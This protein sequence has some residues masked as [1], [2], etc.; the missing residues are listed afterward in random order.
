M[1]RIDGRRIVWAINR[2]FLLHGA[3]L[4]IGVI[5][6]GILLTLGI[7]LSLSQMRLR[8]ARTLLTGPASSSEPLAIVPTTTSK[9]SSL[10]QA[11]A[12]FD[13]TRRM[14]GVLRKGGLEP[15]QI[16]FKYERSEDS[17]LY[18]QVA[19]FSVQ[20]PWK[21]VGETLQSLQTTDRAV[22]ISKLRLTRESIEQETV[23]AEVQLSHVFL[24]RQAEP[25]R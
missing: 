10:P 24:D 11:D 23:E 18:R 8:E 2:Q 1:A 3:G 14:L 5:G 9:P 15:V 20:A 7:T 12:R 6:G 21:V 22:Y 19:D 4:W 13:S 16:K 25:A 17:G